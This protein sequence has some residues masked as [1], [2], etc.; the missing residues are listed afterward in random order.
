MKD[1]LSQAVNELVPEEEL[2]RLWRRKDKLGSRYLQMLRR[3]R[4]P[5]RMKRS[6]PWI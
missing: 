4:C 5:L 1:D 2:K 3:R 6:N